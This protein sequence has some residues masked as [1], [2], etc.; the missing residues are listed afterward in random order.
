MLAWKVHKNQKIY[1]I[2]N[3]KTVKN[4]GDITEARQHFLD[5]VSTHVSQ[6]PFA[7]NLL[8]VIGGQLEASVCCKHSNKPMYWCSVVNIPAECPEALKEFVKGGVFSMPCGLY[9]SCRNW[10]CFRWADFDNSDSIERPHLASHIGKHT[11]GIAHWKA[12]NWHHTF[13]SF[14]W[15]AHNWHRT[16][17]RPK[18]FICPACR[19]SLP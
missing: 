6:E 19:M 9:D 7:A 4:T 12:H 3:T 10:M 13:G 18:Y 8:D 17:G 16:F 1:D 2:M 15:E 14:R 11:T 5:Q